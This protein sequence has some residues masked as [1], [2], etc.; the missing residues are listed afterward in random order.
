MKQYKIVGKIILSFILPDD[1][2]QHDF[3]LNKG[4]I[5]YDEKNTLWY[6]EES[7]I[8]LESITTANVIELALRRGD[9][10]PVEGV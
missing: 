2:E 10:I 3:I 5:E 8:K 1:D 7:G 9:I 4:T 6:V